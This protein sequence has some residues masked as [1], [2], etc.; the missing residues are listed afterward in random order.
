[1]ASLGAIFS[2]ARLRLKREMK[3]RLGYRSIFIGRFLAGYRKP[4]NGFG[5]ENLD[6]KLLE[7]IDP[8]PNYFIELGANDGVAQSNTLL[9]ELYFG[10]SGVLIEPIFTSFESLKRNR[11]ARRNFLL[12]AAC[13]SAEFRDSEVEMVYSNLMS[14]AIGLDS[15]VV[16]AFDHARQGFQF[17]EQGD[18]LRT[19]KV[20]AMTLTAALR[21]ANAPRKIGL[22][23]LD[24]EGAELEVLRGIDFRSFDIR[25]ILVE[26]RNLARIRQH[27]APLG[28]DFVATLSSHDYLFERKGL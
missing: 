17:L 20:P 25:W 15:D 4:E 26:S 3:S 8:S 5:L 27:L 9:L 22:L 16:D 13:V 14:T 6:I 28:Y 10:W 11:S 2:D 23:S 1:M 12:H 18:S 21:L 19:E 7:H 24:V